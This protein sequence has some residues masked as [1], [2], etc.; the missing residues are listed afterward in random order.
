L[1][2]LATSVLIALALITLILG[3][4]LVVAAALATQARPRTLE[5]LAGS[6]AARLVS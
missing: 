6:V 5:G 1:I 2:A 3:L 4:S